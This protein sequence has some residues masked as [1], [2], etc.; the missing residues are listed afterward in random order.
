VLGEVGHLLPMEVPKE[1]ARYAA[2][3]IGGEMAR[4]RTE[5]A[6]Y[7]EWVKKRDIEK[8]TLSEDWK[9]YL[10]RPDRAP[11]PGKAKI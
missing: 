2:E 3:W 8:T 1:C 7:E 11:P 10:P 4:W 9:T 5:Q 6:A